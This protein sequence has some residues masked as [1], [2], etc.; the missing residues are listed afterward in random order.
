MQNGIH[1]PT[2][3]FITSIAATLSVHLYKKKPSMISSY[4][5]CIFVNGMQ[6]HQTYQSK[7]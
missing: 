3:K 4:L 5:F 2:R 7:C 1:V 6:P